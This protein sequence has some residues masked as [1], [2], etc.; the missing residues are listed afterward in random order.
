MFLLESLPTTFYNSWHSHQFLIWHRT[1][2]YTLFSECQREVNC[3]PTSRMQQWL[4]YSFWVNQ[5]II[6][7]SFNTIQKS[8]SSSKIFQIL[9]IEASRLFFMSFP[10]LQ[11]TLKT[12][13]PVTYCIFL[14]LWYIVFN[15]PKLIVIII[16]YNYFS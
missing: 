12:K 8:E 5:K 16:N 7:G 3:N 10:L 6:Y 11:W 1:P 4:R 2:L 15:I 14:P 9:K 13:C